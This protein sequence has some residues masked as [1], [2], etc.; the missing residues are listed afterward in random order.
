MGVTGSA[1]MSFTARIKVS[2]G[3]AAIHVL[4][5]PPIY[6][7]QPMTRFSIPWRK[8]NASASSIASG[9]SDSPLAEPFYL[10]PNAR[11]EA[12]ETQTNNRLCP[13]CVLTVR[14]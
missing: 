1:V 8:F 13:V 10:N 12:N 7:P 4:I 2:N 3:S 9:R 14:W 11:A 5:S 6:R